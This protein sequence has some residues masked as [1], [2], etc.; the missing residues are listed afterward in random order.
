MTPEDIT[1]KLTS[2]LE[3]VVPKN[4]W[5]ETSLFYNPGHLLPNGVYFCTLKE[6][7]GD[8]DRASN[9]DRDGVYRLSIGLTKE[10]Y[11]KLFGEKPG[12]SPDRVGNHHSVTPSG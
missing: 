5:G 4:S 12:S 11:E 7:D 9:L 1:K 6:K 8:N 3:G 2:R 10:G